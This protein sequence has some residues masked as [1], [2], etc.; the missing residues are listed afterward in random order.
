MKAT[1]SVP[2]ADPDK[3]YVAIEVV[4]IGDRKTELTHVAGLYS[5]SRLQ[6][7]RGKNESNFLVMNPAFSTQFPCFLEPGER[8]LGGIE[9][10]Q[11]LEEMSRNGLLYCGVIH[12]A[13]AKAL[14][15]RVVINANATYLHHQHRA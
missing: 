5:K 10:T 12:S 8:W 9:Q 14:T 1:G 6:H 15:K 13:S 11:E 4:N 2:N 3:S 7:F